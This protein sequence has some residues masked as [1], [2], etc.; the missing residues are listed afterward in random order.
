MDKTIRRYTSFEAM[1]ADEFREWQRLS[2]Y[3][4]IKAT[5][6]LSFFLYQLKEPGRDLRRLQRTL[7]SIQRTQS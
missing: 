3:E 7:V 5:A 2:G 4:R 6:E 1:K